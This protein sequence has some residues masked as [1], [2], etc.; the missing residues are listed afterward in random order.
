MRAPSGASPG[1]RTRAA[2]FAALGLPV[3]GLVVL[4][5]VLARAAHDS[6]VLGLP[7]AL[8]LDGAAAAAA[9]L[10]ILWHRPNHAVGWILFAGGVGVLLQAD[11]VLLSVVH[12]RRHADP[13][14]MGPAAVLAGQL[15]MPLVAAIPHGVARFPDGRVPLRGARA[16]TWVTAAVVAAT[17]AYFYAHV[18]NELVAGHVTI[19]RSSGDPV[20]VDNPQGALAWAYTAWAVTVVATLVLAVVALVIKSRRADGITRQQLR[21]FITGSVPT[22]AALIPIVA[23]SNLGLPDDALANQLLIW[24]FAAALAALPATIVVGLL[25]FRLYELDIVISRS[26]TYGLLAAG[27][28][29]AYLL[30]VTLLGVIAGGSDH[31]T[32]LSIVATLSAAALFQPMRAGADRLARRLVFGP[33][34]TPYEALGE[35]AEQLSSTQSLDTVLSRAA[36]VLAEATAA[37]STDVWL[38]AEDDTLHPVATWPPSAEP[39]ADTT[40]PELAAA[41]GPCRATVLVAHEGEVLG[42]LTVTKR[43]NEPLTDSDRNLLQ[44]LA[45]Q[46]GLV[47]RNAKLSADLSHRLDELLA[48]RQRLVAAQDEAR[49]LLERDLH[50]GAQQQL[51]AVNMRLGRLRTQVGRLDEQLADAVARLQTDVDSAI[52]NIRALSRG[53]YPSVLADKGLAAALQSSCRDA[54]VPVVV[55]GAVT[56]GRLPQE[57]EAAAYFCVMEALQNVFRHADA[58]RAVVSLRRDDDRLLIE[59]RDDGHGFLPRE[60]PEGSGLLNISDRVEALQGRITVRSALGRGSS[61]AM[62][63]PLPKPA[64][65]GDTACGIAALPA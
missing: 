12:Y 14:P 25:R 17:T 61:V 21:W 63:F 24:V 3:V 13:L 22:A 39:P 10:V 53:I 47:L 58:S 54:P 30:V 65:A 45:A 36:E 42:A 48:S 2:R 44:Q 28:T 7:G 29:A 32:G 52:D 18:I 50:D 19:S 16:G 4:Y 64:D 20:D 9:G 8:P 62:N 35:F 43:A 27:I 34:A 41:D 51:I 57:V 60:R 23:M 31:S 15:W 49:R 55:D 40:L 6:L 1:R 38:R 37:L 26:I 46:A 59:V 11:G 33:R 5:A 56:A